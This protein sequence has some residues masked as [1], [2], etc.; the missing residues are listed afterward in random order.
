[1]GFKITL[2]CSGIDASA[3]A[4]AA[5]DIQTEFHDH[6]QWHREVHCHYESGTMILCGINDFDQAGLAFLDEFGDCLSAYLKDHGTV[7]VL[8]VEAV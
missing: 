7:R 4:I 1:M 8:S 6:R 2:A 5:Q 3:G